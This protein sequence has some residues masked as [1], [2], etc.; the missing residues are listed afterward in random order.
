[1]NPIDSILFNS[2]THRL[3]FIIIYLEQLFHY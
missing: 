1:M 2:N 3:D